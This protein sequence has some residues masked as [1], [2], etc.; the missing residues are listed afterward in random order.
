M[1]RIL[2]APFTKGL[3]IESPHPSL[4]LDVAAYGIEVERLDAV[5]DAAALIDALRRT[6]AQVLFK[7]SRVPVTRE[8][9]EACP[10]LHHVQLCCI[11]DDSVDTEAATEHG[12]LVCNDPV[13][14]ARSVV[15]LAIGHLVAL[16]RRLHETNEACHQH[17]WDK[18]HTG[19]FEIADKVLGVVGLGN[20]GRQVARAAEALGV[21]IQFYDS[22]PVAQEV[23]QEMGWRRVD[24]LAALFR[25][26]DMVTVHTSAK[27]AWG[28]DNVDFLND[29]LGQLAAE[30]GPRSPRLYLNL[31]RGNLHSEAALLEAVAAGAIRYAAVDVY[32]AE[33][34][35]GATW[36]NPYAAEPRIICTPHIGAATQEAQ[37]RIA[38]RVARTVGELSRFG[39]LRDCVYSP[40]TVLGLPPPSPGHAVLAV[41]HSTR[42]GTKKAVADAIYEAEASTL[43]STQQDFPNGIAY[44]LSVLD[45]PLPEAE[46]RRLV[47]RASALAGDPTAVRAV[48]Q[49]V[50]PARW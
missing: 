40:R 17:G 32:P 34:R 31:A 20:I 16:A 21:E 4:D 25:T 49:V 12:L 33:P 19:R 10:D 23:G 48:R 6:G 29:M 9:I 35:P 26:S 24:D 38:R 30:R 39:T 5:P 37:P 41:V 44:D 11:G 36:V 1:A 8:V 13:S 22:R 27:D 14:N 50:I 2:M 7:R 15:E 43:G 3:V 47:E 42:R 45:R 18:S 46:L 28:H